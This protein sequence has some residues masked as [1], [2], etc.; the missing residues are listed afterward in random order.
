MIKKIL[1]LVLLIVLASLSV[2]HAV[3][4]DETQGADLKKVERLK[5]AKNVT[6]ARVKK[7]LG[8]PDNVVQIKN[9]KEKCKELWVYIYPI[10]EGYMPVKTEFLYIDFDA[11]GIMCG[12]KIQRHAFKSGK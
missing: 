9:K 1:P 2:P 5:T 3:I 4:A 12:A 10:L 6:R 8:K 7:V 11:N